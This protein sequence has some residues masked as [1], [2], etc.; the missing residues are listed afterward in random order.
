MLILQHLQ[1]GDLERLRQTCHFFRSLITSPMLKK[2]FGD[3]LKVMLLSHCYLCLKHDPTYVNLLWADYTDPRY[4]F[5]SKCIDCAV[6]RNELMVGRRVSLGNYSTAWVCRWCG[7]PVL[8]ASAW[9]SAVH[10]HKECNEVYIRVLIGYVVL[11]WTQFSIAV[12]GAALCFKYF[13]QDQRV[14]VSCIVSPL[15][16]D[17]G[18]PPEKLTS[19]DHSHPSR[20]VPPSH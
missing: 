10:F 15:Q 17:P 12:V 3:E 7:Y 20:V 13:R 11:G 18:P 8:A 5:A 19:A 9:G 4:P 14:V 1:F 2:L 6:Q 16:A